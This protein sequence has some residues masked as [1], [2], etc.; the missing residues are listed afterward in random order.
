MFNI[1][2]RLNT[3]ILGIFWDDLEGLCLIQE[4][5]PNKSKAQDVVGQQLVFAWLS[6]HGR[7]KHNP[8]QGFW[9]ML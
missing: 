7:S 1:I 3:D 9:G 6:K 2:I 5:S 4:L 8:G